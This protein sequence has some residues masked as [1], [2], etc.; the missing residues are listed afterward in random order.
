[1]A[2]VPYTIIIRLFIDSNTVDLNCVINPTPT[3]EDV[4]TIIVS[5]LNITEQSL[6]EFLIYPNPANTNIH[7]KNINDKTVKSINLYTIYG[8]LIK[9][10]PPTNIK[11]NVREF[12]RGYYILEIITEQGATRKKIVL[13]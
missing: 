10:F 7:I 2:A 8:S 5:E 13:N 9:T 4:D 1:M 3:I 12:K 6:D 11:L